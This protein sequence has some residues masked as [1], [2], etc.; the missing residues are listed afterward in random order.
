MYYALRSNLK[1][2]LGFTLRLSPDDKRDNDAQAEQDTESDNI[3]HCSSTQD[4]QQTEAEDQQT[5]NRH[6]LETSRKQLN[7]IKKH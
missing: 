1:R 3:P 6:H 2:E 7:K 5:W 4:G